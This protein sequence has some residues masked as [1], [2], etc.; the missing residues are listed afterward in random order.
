MIFLLINGLIILCVVLFV[1]LKKRRIK[2]A[3]S[4]TLTILSIAALI[5]FVYLQ[6]ISGGPDSGQELGQMIIPVSIYAI[7][8]FISILVCVHYINSAR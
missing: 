3:L 2:I 7:V 1:F 8:A 5:Q 6:K 4:G